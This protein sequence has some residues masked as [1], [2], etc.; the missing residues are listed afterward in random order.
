[1]V[2]LLRIMV[3]S[4]LGL[5]L[6]TGPAIGAGPGSRLDHLEAGFR[7]LD[8]GG[9]HPATARLFQVQLAGS[10]GDLLAAEG[11]AMAVAR[12][13]SQGRAAQDPEGIPGNEARAAFLEGL[14]ARAEWRFAEAASSFAAAAAL[15]ASGGDSLSVRAAQMEQ[16]RALMRAGDLDGA[17]AVLNLSDNQPDSH[18]LVLR[19]D[20]E[21][22][23]ISADLWN[24]KGDYAKA[25]E[26][27]AAA[28]SRAEAAGLV[29]AQS[30]CLNG[31]G[32]VN[33]RRRDHEAAVVLFAR[34][35]TLAQVMDDPF[36]RAQALTNLAYDETQLRRLSRSRKH[37]E[38]AATL[39]RSCGFTRLLGNIEGSFGGLAEIQGDRAGA[40]GCFRRAL[41]AHLSSRD[42]FGELGSRQRLAYSLLMMGEYPE[43]ISHYRRCVDLLEE[44]DTRVGG[45]WIH[46]GLALAFHKLGNL[47]EAQVHYRRALE[48]SG[49]QGD[50]RSMAWGLDSLGLVRSLRGDYRAALAFFFQAQ[51]LY[52]ELEDSEGLAGVEVSLAGTYRKLG[53]YDRALEHA[54][55]ALDLARSGHYEEV[56]RGAAGETAAI[57]TELGRDE[58]AG[59]H[60]RE[61]LTIAR[62]WSDRDAEIWS[63]CA[64][65]DHHLAGGEKILA[66]ARATEAV[67]LLQPDG[68][69]FLRA[70]ARLLQ[71][72]A[73]SDPRQA[74]ADMTAALAAA[75]QG[76]LP[77][78]EWQCLAEMG[79]A[80]MALGDRAA[81]L[82]AESR[83]M[84]VVESLRNRAGSDE[85]RRHILRPAIK[86]FLRAV[87]LYLA[88]DPIPADIAAAFACT[89][90]SRALTLADRLRSAMAWDGAGDPQAGKEQELLA[91]IG[92][93]QARLQEPGVPA[94]E[95]LALRAEIRKLEDYRIVLPPEAPS[96]LRGEGRDP[97]AETPADW[98]RQLGPRETVLAYFLGEER[99]RLFIVTREEIAVRPLPDAV[100]IADKAA[101]FRRIWS[102]QAA[103]GSKDTPP[104]D[105]FAQAS[106]QLHDLLI[107]PAAEFL[108]P[109]G[110]LVII[111]DGAL[112]NLPFGL[113]E[114]PNGALVAEHDIFITPS[115]RTL[116][117][118]RQRDKHREGF[119]APPLDL[120]AVGASGTDPGATRVHPFAGTPVDPLP[121]A[122]AEARLVGGLFPR[123]LVL[124]GPAA[125]ERSFKGA[126]LSDSRIIHIAAHSFVDP[127]DVRRS[128]IL[129]QPDFRQIDPAEGSPPGEDGLLQWDEIAGL[130]LNASLVT[131]ASCRAAGGVL[132]VG[133][134]ITGLTQAFLHAGASVVLAS[135][136]D[137]PDGTLGPG[138]RAFY[139]HLQ[140]GL[141]AAEALR[142]V[143]AGTGDGSLTGA[144][145]TGF[146]LIGD[147]NV[148]LLRNPYSAG[149]ESL[150]FAGLGAAGLLGLFFCVIRLRRR[151]NT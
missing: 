103:G 3:F 10:P 136:N 56:L 18:P 139:S 59:H 75:R 95:R 12:D 32:S 132:T 127:Q 119:K 77:D 123:S 144:A 15:A 118:L 17:A 79:L 85:L 19:L 50:R 143:Q 89:E 97:A 21:S 145:L 146:V 26:A 125:D 22:A 13:C 38:E 41:E 65:A 37:L 122:A 30:D 44:L 140:E 111:P 51:D 35:L 105:V 2:V 55:L 52:A 9:D 126:P 48:L 94:D 147:G 121:R 45:T 58:E 68:Q 81:A 71:G 114:G 106:R 149:V 33:S 80:H 82:R 31:L 128:F 11:Y 83:A 112:H 93:L 28:L 107:A 88:E 60:L 5:I 6:A 129:L 113:L 39:A 133:E 124:T 36:R 73:A 78:L 142:R 130:D 100:E 23:I 138:L 92:Y 57:Y 86:P 110:T 64:L 76:G 96:S 102:L 1:M 63:L 42:E 141:P 7:L 61:A 24:L 101:L 69:F 62:R 66:A 148:K 131:L 116:A 27:Y 109:G 115:L 90:R 34:A 53:D 54:G 4:L 91:R 137:V 14:R 134:G 87:D 151:S 29:S 72:R 49:D 67:G 135:I 46:G 43:A 16:G 47:A 84:E 99:S 25:E 40:V 74:L 20:I 108:Q 120:L 70:R 98:C 104:A 117:Y 8:G 150:W